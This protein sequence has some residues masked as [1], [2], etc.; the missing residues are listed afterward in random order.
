MFNF[1]S[2]GDKLILIK[3]V[4]TSIPTF[5]MSTLE[6]PTGIVEQINKYLRHCFWRKYGMEDKGTTLIS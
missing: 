5:F 2:Y 6:L 1:L 4:F 3:S